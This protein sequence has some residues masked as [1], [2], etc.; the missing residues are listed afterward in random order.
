MS[1]SA[2]STVTAATIGVRSHT[3]LLSMTGK[4][5]HTLNIDIPVR[6][7][8]DVMGIQEKD[9]ERVGNPANSADIFGEE[10]EDNECQY[11]YSDDE[12]DIYKEEDVED[13]GS[14][15]A[16]RRRKVHY[17]ETEALEVARAWVVQSKAL[18]TQKCANFWH[19]VCRTLK[20][21]TGKNG[22]L[23]SV[24]DLRKRLIIECKLRLALESEM[25]RHG[26]TSGRAELQ[27]QQLVSDFFC[28]SYWK[29]G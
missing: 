27:V 10:D 3:P 8:P 7:V 2:P 18:D 16:G 19:G 20:R 5:Y 24:R 28:V 11:G 21:R 22:E 15:T 14:A 6:M 25:D 29:I 9:L 13:G 26:A 4:R 12:I 23:E 17:N 1:T